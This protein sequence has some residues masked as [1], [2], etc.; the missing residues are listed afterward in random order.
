MAP[1]EEAWINSSTMAVLYRP[2]GIRRGE[3]IGS[4]MKFSNIELIIGVVTEVHYGCLF[5]YYNTN[6]CD[7][8][9]NTH[10]HSKPPNSGLD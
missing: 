2:F 6:R 5:W 4:I 10:L 3:I 8:S 1:H 7:H 9:V